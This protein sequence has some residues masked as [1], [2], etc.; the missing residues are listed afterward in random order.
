MWAFPRPWIPEQVWFSC[1]GA[2]DHNTGPLRQP[3]WVEGRWKP[4]M[5]AGMEGPSRNAIWPVLLLL[6]SV[7]LTVHGLVG[8]EEVDRTC[9]SHE[10]CMPNCA[11][12]KVMMTFD[13]SDKIF[14]VTTKVKRLEIHKSVTYMNRC[15]MFG[16][17]D[18]FQQ[19]SNRCQNCQ[20]AQPHLET[21]QQL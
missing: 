10:T 16:R 6:S 20:V 3:Q 21:N 19:R 2:V 15:E 17:F 1:S 8:V 12:F 13:S 9:Q 14:N 11:F 5:P 7:L 18:R 4:S